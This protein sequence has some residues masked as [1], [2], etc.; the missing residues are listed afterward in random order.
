MKYKVIHSFILAGL[1]TVLLFTGC[2]KDN[3]SNP[4]NNNNGGTTGDKTAVSISGFAFSPA[5]LTVANGVTVTWTNMDAAAHTVTA[6]DNSFTSGTLNT[7]DTYMHKFTAAGT[8]NYHCNFHP[9]MKASV[10]VQ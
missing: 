3:N 7:G 2:K 10:T 9:G 4:S 5:A 6:D 1:F 8:V